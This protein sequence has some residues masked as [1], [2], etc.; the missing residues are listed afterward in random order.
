[1][2]A[3]LLYSYCRY[4]VLRNLGHRVKGRI[5]QAIGG[6]FGKMEGH[7]YYTRGRVL[8]HL[9]FGCHH[10]SARFNLYHL[11]ITN[12]ER[13]SIFGIYL[14]KLRSPQ[15]IKAFHLSC[16]CACMVVI[17]TALSSKDEGVLLIWNFC[18]RLILQRNKFSFAPDKLVLVQIGGAGVF[19]GRAWPLKPTLFIQSLLTDTGVTWGKLRDLFEDLLG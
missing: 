15:Y 9:R 18:R 17:K 1:M 12:S 3:V 19:G 14:Y 4:L 7:R 11:T 10:S 2:L 5:G 16:H 8:R 13:F 6:A